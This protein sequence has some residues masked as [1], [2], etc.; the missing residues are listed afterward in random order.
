MDMKINHKEVNLTP[1]NPIIKRTAYLCYEKFKFNFDKFGYDYGDVELLSSYYAYIYLC[2]FHKND[3]N[4]RNKM[5]SFIRQCFSRLNTAIRQRSKN[6]S[7][8]ATKIMFFKVIDDKKCIDFDKIETQWNKMGL[9]K[10]R[11]KDFNASKKNGEKTLQHMIGTH[12]VEFT[13]EWMGDDVKPYEIAM[14]ERQKRME[15]EEELERFEQMSPQKKIN[16]LKTFIVKN[17][18][19]KNMRSELSICRNM[20]AKLEKK[21]YE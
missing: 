2:N 1:Y 3:D 5:I 6:I 8:V 21:S 14:E 10:V 20:I 4:D 16:V 11:P 18:T 12:R 7:G 13:E 15:F 17:R 19:N 9:Q